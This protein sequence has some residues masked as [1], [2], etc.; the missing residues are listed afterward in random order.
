MRLLS[1]LRQ[2]PH[3]STEGNL[4]SL[5][6]EVTSE[7]WNAGWWDG[8][9]SASDPSVPSPCADSE[10]FKEKKNKNKKETLAFTS[11][12]T[13][14]TTKKTGVVTVIPVSNYSL[15][16]D[17]V[18]VQPGWLKS[19][20]QNTVQPPS[21]ASASLISRF[22]SAKIILT[23]SEHGTLINDQRVCIS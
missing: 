1:W 16:K 15:G 20:F 6:L 23:G 17:Y 2:D 9:N 18:A 8:W 13:F 4:G 22:L 21:Q 11:S 14:Y 12:D 7:A 10:S 19:T 5:I 3:P